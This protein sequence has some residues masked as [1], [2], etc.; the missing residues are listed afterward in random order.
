[1]RGGIATVR[2]DRARSSLDR[3]SQC[4]GR[5]GRPLSLDAQAL[6]RP[7]LGAWGGRAVDARCDHGRRAP[8]GEP[9]LWLPVVMALALGWHYVGRGVRRFVWVA[10]AK[11][12]CPG[13]EALDIAEAGPPAEE[14]GH[15][16]FAPATRPSRPS[17]NWPAAGEYHQPPA[18][19][20]VG[21][22]VF[23]APAAGWLIIGT[24]LATVFTGNAP[25]SPDNAWLTG[26]AGVLLALGLASLYLVSTR[27]DLNTLLLRLAL[28]VVLM[29]WWL[30]R[31]RRRWF[32]C[33]ACP[34]RFIC[35]SG[36]RSRGSS[37]CSLAPGSR[38]GRRSSSERAERL[39]AWAWQF[40]AALAVIAL[41]FTRFEIQ[42]ET[43]ITLLL[44]TAALGLPAL[45]GIRFCRPAAQAHLE[46]RPGPIPS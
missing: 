2:D 6:S 4:A 5:A 36:R 41:A 35:R 39:D 30:G 24:T 15:E 10:G 45:N 34:E 16:D 8:A 23:G 37:W 40:G 12:S 44:A 22:F 21:C 3:L 17:T 20:S 26:W 1:M 7:R 18:V 9:L 28:V 42:N 31:R 13:G 46:R 27:R 14:P 43:A 32:G 33:S 29:V 25:M 38:A 11:S 19:W